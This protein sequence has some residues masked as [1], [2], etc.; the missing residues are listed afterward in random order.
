[1]II[2]MIACDIG[3][4]TSRESQSADTLLRYRVRAYLH[5]GIFTTLVRHS[6]KQSVQRDRVGGSMICRNCFIVYIITYSREQS[7]FIAELAEHII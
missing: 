7:R 4:D 3:K 2:Q 5:E 1:M 6:A